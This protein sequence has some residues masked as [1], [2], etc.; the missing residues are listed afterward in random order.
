MTCCICWYVGGE[1]PRDAETMIRGY[2][3][4][5]PHMGYV[6]QGTEWHAILSAAKG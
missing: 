2:A 3:V 6:A 5:E 4:C 1:D